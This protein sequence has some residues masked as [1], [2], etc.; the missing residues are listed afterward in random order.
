MRSRNVFEVEVFGN[1]AVISVEHDARQG[2]L[3]LVLSAC[4]NKDNEREFKALALMNGHRG[5]LVLV[6]IGDFDISFLY[7][8][9]H[10]LKFFCYAREV[11]TP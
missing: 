4:R 11:R 8:D 3:P 6:G 10:L 7:V 9:L 5:D 2:I 1:E